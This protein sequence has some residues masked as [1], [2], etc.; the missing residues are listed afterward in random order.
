MFL[1]FFASLIVGKLRDFNRNVDPEQAVPEKSLDSLIPLIE[2][3]N[4]GEGIKVLD[5][6]IS[7]PQ[8]RE[9]YYFF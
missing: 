5:K 7:W 6:L 2:G 9:I 3:S 1:F 4:S 8:G